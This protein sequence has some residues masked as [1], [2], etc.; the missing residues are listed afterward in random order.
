MKNNDLVILKR[1]QYNLVLSI[2]LSNS[3]EIECLKRKL[4]SQYST[5][6]RILLDEKVRYD[7]ELKSELIDLDEKI[8][9]LSGLNK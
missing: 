1:N 7:H 2:R 5:K 6:E 3:D 8:N 4:E 9:N